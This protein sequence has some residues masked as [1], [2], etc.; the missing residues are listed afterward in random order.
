MESKDF[1]QLLENHDKLQ[2][3]AFDAGSNPPDSLLAH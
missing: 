1:Y 3:L 2:I